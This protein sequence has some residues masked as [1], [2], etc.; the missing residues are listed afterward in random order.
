MHFGVMLILRIVRV[1]LLLDCCVG[2]LLWVSS[3]NI[4]I[5]YFFLV[6]HLCTLV[7]G[8][9]TLRCSTMSRCFHGSFFFVVTDFDAAENMLANYQ[10]ALVC[11]GVQVY[12]CFDVLMLECLNEIL[13]C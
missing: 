12:G 6:R 4:G 9:D 3:G 10:N 1:I 5:R 2:A 8:F 13:C 7:R 11:C